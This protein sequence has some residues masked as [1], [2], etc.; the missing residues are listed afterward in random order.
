MARAIKERNHV[1]AIGRPLKIGDPVA[2]ACNTTSLLIGRITALGE[3]KIRVVNY[4]SP[5]RSPDWR[6]KEVANGSL[7]YPAE[8]V[9]LDG[10]DILMY[11]LKMNY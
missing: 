10:P 9:L 8:A 2:V 5:D 7:R 6:G 1:D 4:G 11:L 3:K